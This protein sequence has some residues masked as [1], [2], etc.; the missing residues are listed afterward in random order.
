VKGFGVVKRRSRPVRR[1]GKSASDE[2]AERASVFLMDAGAARRA[3]IFGVGTNCAVDGIARRRRVNDAD[4]AR[5]NRLRERGDEDPT[6]DE[7][8]NAS[9][10]SVVSLVVKLE[11]I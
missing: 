9:T 7:S 8:R 4:D 11:K 2:L 3:V 10:H 5:Q 6:T 1:G